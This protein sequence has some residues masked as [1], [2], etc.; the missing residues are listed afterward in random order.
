MRGEAGVL[1]IIGAMHPGNP[2]S[3][4]Y[5]V[6]QVRRLDQMA[7][8]DSG[9]PGPELMQ[10]AAQAAFS[11]L[12]RRW[13]QARSLVIVAGNGNNGG[14][15]FLL[16]C[17]AH[18]AN[19]SVFL[20]AL[21]E[22]SSGDAAAARQA[23]LDAGGE[24]ELAGAD[25]PFPDADVLVDGLF[26]T[27]LSR[28]P[29][30]LAADLIE[31]MD[32]FGGPRLA[33]DVPSG[34]DADLGIVPGLALRADATISFVGW[35][36][37]MFSAD[38]PDHCGAMELATLGIP[39]DLHA[40][41]EADVQLLDAELIGTL[42][43][44]RRNV[45]KG[46]F[47]HVLVVGGDHSMAGAVRLTGEA[48][49]RSGAGLV[50]VATRAGNAPAINAARPELMVQGVDGPQS[51]VPFLERASVVALGPGLGQSSWAHALWD[52][53]LCAGKP[54]V[55]DADGLNFLAS[56]PRPLPDRC[57][58][59]PHPGEAARLLGC[60]VATVQ[61][62]RFAA[63]RAL[64]ARY[65]AIVVLKG[66]G[67]LVADAQGRLALCPFGNPGMA[68]AGMGDVLTGVIAGLMAQGLGSRDA[69]CL[70][71]LVHALAG[72]RAAGDRPRG[73]LASD[74]FEPLRACLN[75]TSA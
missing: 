43:V 57:V 3:A 75:G 46:T 24:I 38:G 28:A 62:D 67:S 55:L 7:I 74:L 66:C 29:T 13:P 19:F 14:D 32:R 64:A 6:G 27:G 53:A 42:G 63:A 48:A 49:V 56:H 52:T 31:R 37:G 47:G 72:D 9:I 34:L 54:L 44:R 51:I 65:S 4:L 21:G 35:K 12:Q 22:A 23:W 15:A 58:L 73:L 39:H 71:V 50:S 45:N 5:T 20:T 60:D 18:E 2:T 26:G 16:A 33:L 40:R 25:V 8:N 30:G 69:A 10:R 68:S 1:R 59:T 36:R 41:I 11:S 61:S 17:L 70:G